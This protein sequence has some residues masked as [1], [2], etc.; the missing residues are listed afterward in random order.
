MGGDLLLEPLCSSRQMFCSGERFHS[1]VV[2]RGIFEP[3]ILP[4]VNIKN[5]LNYGPV[6]LKAVCGQIHR[7]KI[8]P[9]ESK[10]ISSYAYD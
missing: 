5:C 2:L 10:H 4:H 6:N 3:G 9:A 7:A 8:E 1:L